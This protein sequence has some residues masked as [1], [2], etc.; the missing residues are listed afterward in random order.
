MS[1]APQRL[2]P[3]RWILPIAVLLALLATACGGGGGGP[4]S[5]QITVP[6]GATGSQHVLGSPQ[7]PIELIEYADFQ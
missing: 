6:P 4:G 7:A 5:P 3:L 2:L 1:E